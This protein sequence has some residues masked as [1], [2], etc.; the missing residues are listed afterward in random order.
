MRRGSCELVACRGGEG[1]LGAY[2]GGGT[3]KGG[4]LV[5]GG[6]LIPENALP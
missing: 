6:S 2:P 1:L 4:W 3:V 5:L